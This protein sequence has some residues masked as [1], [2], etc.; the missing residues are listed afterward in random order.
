M[1]TETEYYL[2]WLVYLAATAGCLLV[3]WRLTRLSHRVFS[4]S[5]RI[6]VT[7]ML[8]VPALV[9]P[10]AD[11]MAPALV[12]GVFE[13]LVGDADYGRQVLTIMLGAMFGVLSVYWIGAVVCRQIVGGRRNTGK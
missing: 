2:A 3:W 11:T 7:V 9:G 4:A 5:L 13:M 10:E 1:L 12:V 6:L 8:L